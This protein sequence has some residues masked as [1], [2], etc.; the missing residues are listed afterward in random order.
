[1]LNWGAGSL[2]LEAH[3]LA[4]VSSMLTVAGCYEAKPADDV[5]T[6]KMELGTD[7]RLDVVR[8]DAPDLDF[9]LPSA[10]SKPQDAKPPDSK[11]DVKPD[12][13][14]PDSK[15]D[16]KPDSKPPDSKPDS[17]PD[18]SAP[19]LGH[20]QS[21]VDIYSRKPV[22]TFTSRVFDSTSVAPTYTTLLLVSQ[23]PP[24]TSLRL[25]LRSAS[26][27]TA[28]N[29]ATWL[30]PGSKTYYEA[31]SGATSHKINKLHN[32]QRYIQ[33]RATLAHDLG[34]TPVLDRIKIDFYP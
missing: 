8:P 27:A 6:S 4:F 15:P 29:N 2:R 19:D 11:P 21:L 33:Y 9:D 30:G 13:K 25:Q 3:A 5:G 12:S 24:R 1:M 7:A 26:S 14:P 22:Q 16:A 17:K 34:S 10:D 28:I 32:G 20:P 23:V 18:S 31:A